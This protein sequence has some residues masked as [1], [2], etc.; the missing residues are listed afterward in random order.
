MPQKR[1]DAECAKKSRREA[2]IPGWPGHRVLIC[3]LPIHSHCRV[4]TCDRYVSQW[5]RHFSIIINDVIIDVNNIF[6]Y[7]SIEVFEE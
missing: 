6:E 2:L 7:L 5:M 3:D 4:L 1:R